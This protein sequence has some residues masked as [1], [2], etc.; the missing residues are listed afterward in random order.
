MLK[1]FRRQLAKLGPALFRLLALTWRIRARGPL[2]PEPAVVA[3]W[4]GEMLPVWKHLA[5]RRPHALVSR[6]RDGGL[7]TRLL[8]GWGYT[9]IRGSSSK[10]NKEAWTE[11][12]TAARRHRVL[13]TP[14]GPRGPAR[15]LKAGAVVAAHRAGV[16][17]YLCRVRCRWA[18]RGTHWDNFLIPLPGAAIALEFVHLPVPADAD[19]DTIDR[20]IDEAQQLLNAA[21]D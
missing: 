7:L 8:E 10:G 3:F 4:H 6:S 17:L 14:D 18:I 12:V 19:R 16:P 9:V 15:V 5:A 21:A 13:L 2:P 20:L 11:L 1:S